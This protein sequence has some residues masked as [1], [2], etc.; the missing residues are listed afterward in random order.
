DGERA[1]IAGVPAVY[2]AGQAGLFDVALAPDFAENGMIYLAYA[3][4]DADR[5]NTELA[6]ARLDLAGRQLQ[7]VEVI[8]RALPKVRGDNHYGGRI[9]FAPDGKLF[10]TL[11]DRFDYRD[12]AQNLANHLGAIVRLNPDG[13]VPE[14]NPFA[15]REDARPEIYSYGHR[16]TQG[17]ARQPGTDVIWA[18]EHGPRGGD[19]V[20]ILEPGANYGWPV[21]T[22]GRE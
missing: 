18:H 12:E 13:S 6:R 14:D 21:V 19:E 1:E 7:D 3:G 4:G 2:A 8:F 16:N 9:L 17:I 11:G 20:N 15:G 10:L 5:N 22:F